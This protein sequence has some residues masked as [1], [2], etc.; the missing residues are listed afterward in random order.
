[1][2]VISCMLADEVDDRHLGPAGVVQIRETIGKAGAKMQE[3]AGW[4]F[5]H[6]GI[7]IRRSR[8]NSFEEAEHAAHFRQPV[9]R[10]HE[11]NLRRTRVRETRVHPT[12]YEGAN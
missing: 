12:R 1:M 5:R 8:A 6:P 10:G 7:A 11:M 2:Q 4:F 9:E 3:G